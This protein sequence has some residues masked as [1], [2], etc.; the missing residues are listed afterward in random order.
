MLENIQE[1]GNMT[2]I[3]LTRPSGDMLQKAMNSLQGM[4]IE[5]L[6][7][8]AHK[9]ILFVNQ[10]ETLYHR[11][12]EQFFQWILLCSPH[13]IIAQWFQ[14]KLQMERLLEPLKSWNLLMI[15]ITARKYEMELMRLSS[16]SHQIPLLHEA[17][18]MMQKLTQD[19][20][21]TADAKPYP[22]FALEGSILFDAA[23]EWFVTHLPEL[24]E[25][26]TQC[27]WMDLFSTFK[28]RMSDMLGDEI[29]TNER[30]SCCIRLLSFFY[31][32][33]VNSSSLHALKVCIKSAYNFDK[34]SFHTNMDTSMATFVKLLDNSD[35]SEEWKIKCKSDLLQ[36]F[37]LP[38]WLSNI[39]MF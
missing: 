31:V 26:D 13:S 24:I 17:L 12:L 2:S 37:F 3:V 22:S 8:V 33:K 21:C 7:R 1:D 23:V 11:Y 39:N 5:T 29:V 25:G 32:L 20:K 19:K 10:S 28:H 38:Q 16:F 34:L 36:H 4:S 30:T 27:K 14:D 6:S 15:H 35:K 9:T 18:D